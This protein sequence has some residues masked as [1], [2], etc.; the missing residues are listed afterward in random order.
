MVH[1]LKM[2]PK[3]KSIEDQIAFFNKLKDLM[4]EYSM[5]CIE[6]EEDHYQYSTH[7]SGV[8]FNFD[9]VYDSEND[10]VRYGGQPTLPSYIDQNDI[11]IVVKKLQQELDEELKAG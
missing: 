4:K 8:C 1:G 2:N 9:W 7:V 5:S 3:I 11:N 6:A 10:V